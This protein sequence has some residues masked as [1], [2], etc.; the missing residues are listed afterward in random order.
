[1]SNRFLNILNKTNN[2]NIGY[3]FSAP[4]SNSSDILTHLHALLSIELKTTELNEKLEADHNL[5][6]KI[7][8]VLCPLV[9]LNEVNVSCIDPKKAGR[10]RSLKPS[11]L[12]V[13]TVTL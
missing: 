2:N 6:K 5:V 3:L 10:N 8:E 4:N 13:L 7:N 1:M 11:L 12:L 9:T